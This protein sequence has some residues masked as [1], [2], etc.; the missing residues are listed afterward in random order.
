LTE[1]RCPRYALSHIYYKN[2]GGNSM[3]K[4]SSII[5][6]LC[7]IASI[8]VMAGCVSGSA[9]KEEKKPEV[10]WDGITALSPA[11]GFVYDDMADGGSSVNLGTF[12]DGTLI[13]K[14]S[15]TDQFQYGFIGVGIIMTSELKNRLIFGTGIKFK[16]KGDGKSYRCKME[17][18]KVSDYD[19]FGYVFRTSD[20]E[21]LVEIP[22]TKLSQEGWGAP[23]QFNPKDVFQISFQTIGQPHESIYLEIKD[24]EIIPIQE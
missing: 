16:V 22:Y 15:V 6:S 7:I 5:I 10:E 1:R 8:F 24:M 4:L 21:T 3:K 17:S 23:V 13:L 12:E 9:V 19:H 20:E 14:G 2:A 18:R 11:E